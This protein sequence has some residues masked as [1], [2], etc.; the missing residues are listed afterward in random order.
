MAPGHPNPG[1]D[2]HGMANPN[3]TGSPNSNKNFAFG[4]AA[5]IGGGAFVTNAHNVCELRGP[6][7]TTIIDA[8]VPGLSGELQ[9]GYSNGILIVSITG[10]PIG[11]GLMVSNMVTNTWVKPL[12]GRN[13]GCH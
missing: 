5:G 9:I 2:A 12:A 3:S 13:C 10:S 1:G 6:F 7:N 8:G 11:A 4:T